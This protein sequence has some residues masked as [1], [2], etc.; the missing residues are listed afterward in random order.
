LVAVGAEG[1]PSEIV[2]DT[3]HGVNDGFVLRPFDYAQGK[4]A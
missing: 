3:S 4:L 1:R 2:N